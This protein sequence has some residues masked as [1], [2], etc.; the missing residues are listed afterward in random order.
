MSDKPQETDPERWLRDCLDYLS[1]AIARGIPA[2]RIGDA[3]VGHRATVEKARAVFE[4][5]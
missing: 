1:A 4:G 2:S 5:R 3:E